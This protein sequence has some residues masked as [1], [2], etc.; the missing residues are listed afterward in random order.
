MGR[1]SLMSCHSVWFAWAAWST[2]IPNLNLISNCKRSIL[3]LT[4]DATALCQPSGRR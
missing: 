3:V 4:E 1:G 2:Q